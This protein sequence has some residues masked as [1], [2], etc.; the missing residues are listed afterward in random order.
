MGEIGGED[1]W[2]SDRLALPESSSTTNL[3]RLVSSTS[4]MSK[5]VV[6]VGR[7]CVC[8]ASGTSIAL[9][10]PSS[11]PGLDSRG[12]V[13]AST[14]SS[15]SDLEGGVSWAWG[16]ES[17]TER[18]GVHGAFSTGFSTTSS[19]ADATSLASKTMLSS[20]I[21]SAASESSVVSS[22]FIGLLGISSST[23]GSETTLM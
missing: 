6:S 18:R 23:S 16:W 2:Y 3:S 22:P 20:I 19:A 9:A 12:L 13:G 17:R 15:P 14:N 8:P 7:A 21:S 1:R 10:T 5:E 4:L 11:C